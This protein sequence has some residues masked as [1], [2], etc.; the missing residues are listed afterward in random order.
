MLPS[1]LPSH[2]A[3]EAAQRRAG[4]PAGA[5]AVP[6]EEAART[7]AAARDGGDSERGDPLVPRGRAPAAAWDEG[8][9]YLGTLSY[10]QHD[11]AQAARAFARFVALKP[12]S[13]PAWAL[14]G[15]SEFDRRSYDASMRYL[16]AR[17]L[18]AAPSATP[19]SATRSTT[20]W[21]LLRI[22]A[23]QFVLAVE[24]LSALARAEP[25]QPVAS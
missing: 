16:D 13:G 4:G 7:A 20:T 22:R 1:R 10:E 11:S 6:F 2:R 15:L 25:R 5:P 14:R 19:R 24:P 3:A 23:G 18:A 17:P 9:W 12:D 21:P 8:W